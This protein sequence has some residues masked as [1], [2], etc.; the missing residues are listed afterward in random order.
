MDP[1]EAESLF[2]KVRGFELG[3]D[4]GD[5]LVFLSGGFQYEMKLLYSVLGLSGDY[6]ARQEAFDI[7]DSWIG[8]NP[9]FPLVPLVY[10]ADAASRVRQR[11]GSAKTQSSSHKSTAILVGSIAS[12]ALYSA[13]KALRN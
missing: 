6:A 10:P 5:L 12:A 9:D 2:G 11:F 1:R 4:E 7:V 3:K 13:S 8:G